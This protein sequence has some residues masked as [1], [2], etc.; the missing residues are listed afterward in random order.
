RRFAPYN[1]FLGMDI[2]LSP[3]GPVLIEVNDIFD[4]G[5]FESVVGP[6]FKDPEV[7]R[8][9]KEFGLIT[10]RHFD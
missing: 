3:F 9:A 6:V 7:L 8:C 5:R 1:K 2:G 4:C 10:H